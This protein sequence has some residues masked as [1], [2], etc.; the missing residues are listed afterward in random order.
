VP[1][2]QGRHRRHLIVKAPSHREI[3]DVLQAL[4]KAPRPRG[5]VE[6][7]WDVDPVGVL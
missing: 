4:R 6:E 3:A 1:R 2:V 7:A 5:G